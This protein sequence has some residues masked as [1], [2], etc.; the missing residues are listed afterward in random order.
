M[1]YASSIFRFFKKIITAEDLVCLRHPDTKLSGLPSWNDE[2]RNPNVESNPND[3]M[4]EGNA[5]SIPPG[6]GTIRMTPPSTLA[7]RV[8]PTP[9][10]ISSTR[11]CSCTI[12]SSQ[13]PQLKMLRRSDSSSEIQRTLAEASGTPEK[14]MFS[15][16]VIRSNADNVHPQFSRIA[17]PWHK[18][19]R[20]PLP[21]H[22]NR[23]T[24][25]AGAS[26]P[27]RGGAMRDYVGW[28][29]S[30]FRFDIR[31]PC[32]CNII[33]SL[34]QIRVSSLSRLRRTDFIGTTLR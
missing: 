17:E 26:G 4:S 18:Y 33:Y 32:Q 29:V 12:R 9:H 19:I 34:I 22:V 21:L 25:H 31:Q 5:F 11:I 10:V 3:R 23:C 2:C 28:D 6:S 13:M 20:E 7:G 24:R 1:K 16:A 30:H 14:K 8:I 27:H 15:H